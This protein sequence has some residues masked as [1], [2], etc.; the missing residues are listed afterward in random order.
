MWTQINPYTSKM[1]TVQ[2]NPALGTHEDMNSV[3]GLE[4]YKKQRYGD[5]PPVCQ[6]NKNLDKLTDLIYF[7]FHKPRHYPIN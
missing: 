2:I 6:Y 4:A 3:E 1:K 5:Y 7:A